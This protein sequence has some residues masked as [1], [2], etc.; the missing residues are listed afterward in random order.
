[1]QP[2]LAVCAGLLCV[3]YGLRASAHVK[4]EARRLARWT[5]LLPRVSLLIAE[6][7]RSLPEAMRLAADEPHPPDR[8]LHAVADAVCTDPLL[9]L[10]EAFAR[11]CPPCTEH[12]T[13][14]RM[15]ERLGR[16]SAESR[17]LA[18]VQAAAALAQMSANVKD[19]AAR[20]ARLYAT[21]GFTGGA[22]LAILLL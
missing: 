18:V 17:R 13:L 11:H 12:E 16:G 15:H 10:A 1:M 8:L 7:T 14:M 21:L 3:L 2:F 6:E 4:V 19:R 9:S 22:C 20:D 5:V